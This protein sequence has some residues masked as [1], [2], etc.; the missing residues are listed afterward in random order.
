MGGPKARALLLN[1]RCPQSIR[2]GVRHV[3]G[4]CGAALVYISH[5]YSE[6]FALRPPMGAARR[7]AHWRSPCTLPRWGSF[8]LRVVGR[9]VI[10][11]GI[12]KPR[13]VAG[14][15]VL[16]CAL[17][18]ALDHF[19]FQVGDGFGGG[20]AFGAGLGAIHNR[21][22]TIKTERVFQIIEALAGGFVAAVLDPAVGL[23]QG[24]GAEIAV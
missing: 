18:F 5:G 12:K 19:E 6:R 24:S 7:R 13:R 15:F 2:S 16:L 11:I 14:A 1:F 17:V 21:V 23:Q 22:A 3:R 9:E 10:G 4:P 20:E 8:L